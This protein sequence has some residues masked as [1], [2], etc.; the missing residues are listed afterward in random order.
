MSSD[1]QSPEPDDERTRPA[2]AEHEDSETGTEQSTGNGQE[3]GA[4]AE[5]AT[6]P[7]D[8]TADAGEPGEAGDGARPARSGPPRP[9]VFVAAALA[10]ASLVVAIVFGVQWQ[11]AASSD[12]VRI[13]ESREAVVAAVG[14]AVVAFT[15]LDSANP[16][17][18]FRRQKDIATGDLLE[19]ISRTEQEY[20]EPISKAK[21]KV[22]SRVADVAVEELNV[23][24]GKALALAVVELTVT[25]EK[26]SG[27]KTLRMQ[28]R[29]ERAPGDSP[30][31]SWKV[32][33]ISPVEYGASG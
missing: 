12:D 3:A 23:H 25:Q 20:R 22:D 15:G 10:S 14:K 4:E 7:E 8:G 24:E 9:F 19:E 21:T 5:A 33:G 28:L 29:M 26:G 1:E 27:T 6:E 2:T 17:E 32:A 13:A 30:E 16:G 18:Y 31:Q 11:S